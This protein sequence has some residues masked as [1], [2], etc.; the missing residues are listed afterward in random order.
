MFLIFFAPFYSMTPQ[1]DYQ[2]GG[3][4]GRY[5]LGATLGGESRSTRNAT[6]ELG[7]TTLDLKKNCFRITERRSSQFPTCLYP[8][9]VSHILLFWSPPLQELHVLDIL[10]RPK[11]DVFSPFVRRM[12]DDTSL[13]SMCCHHSHVGSHRVSRVSPR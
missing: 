11:N 4:A 1:S 6:D 8:A 10:R 13:L 2:I 3:A 7:K 12:C 9:K 5:L